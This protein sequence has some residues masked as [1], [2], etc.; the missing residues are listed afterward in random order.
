MTSIL[1]LFSAETGNMFAFGSSLLQL[2]IF[3]RNQFLSDKSILLIN[4]KTGISVVCI[5]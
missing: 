3:Y 5:L 2:S 1:K 4:T